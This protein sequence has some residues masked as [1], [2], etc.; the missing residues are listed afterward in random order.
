MQIDKETLKKQANYEKSRRSFWHYCKT[1][2]SEFYKEDRPFLKELANSM[3]NF[4][5]SKDEDVL[6]INLPP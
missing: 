5:E 1:I 4:Y 6:L 2:A 3:Q